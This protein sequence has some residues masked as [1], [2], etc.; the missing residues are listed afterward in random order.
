MAFS[1]ACAY[2]RHFNIIVNLE[3]YYLGSNAADLLVTS[4]YLFDVVVF[5]ACFN[6]QFAIIIL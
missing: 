3:Y 2:N 4:Y 6:A 1:A 5:L